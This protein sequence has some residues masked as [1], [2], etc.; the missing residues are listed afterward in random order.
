M[1]ILGWIGGYAWSYDESL[2]V[3]TCDIYSYSLNDDAK[4]MKSLFFLIKNMVFGA[5][6]FWVSEHLLGNRAL[7]SA[8]CIFL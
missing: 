2:K 7:A 1:E 8:P 6:I 4:I 5:C 3:S